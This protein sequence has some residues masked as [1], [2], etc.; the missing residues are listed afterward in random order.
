MTDGGLRMT[1][2]SVDGFYNMLLLGSQIPPTNDGSDNALFYA[3]KR[4]AL[5]AFDQAKLG[6][7]QGPFQ[8]HPVYTRPRDWYDGAI[9]ANWTT[10]TV[11]CDTGTS[12]TSDTPASSSIGNTPSTPPWMWRIARDDLRP[13]LQNSDL[14]ER[15]R[16]DEVV[17]D[18]PRPQFEELPGISFA[19]RTAPAK[20]SAVPIEN[21]QIMPGLEA[22]KIRVS[23]EESHISQIATR[24]LP[25]ISEI[26][27]TATINI[28]EIGTASILQPRLQVAR[29]AYLLRDT[30]SQPVASQQLTISLKYCLVELD[31][32]W[33]SLDYLST[34]GWF[35]PGYAAGWASTGT[36]ENNTG[37]FPVLPIACLVVKDLTIA[38]DA[39][40]D[41]D[42]AQQ[43]AAFGP[44]SLVGRTVDTITGTLRIEGMQIIGWVCQVMP[45]LP[46]LPSPGT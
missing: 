6:S 7:M 4:Q 2:K 38:V 36:A 18:T 28:G 31:R 17:L 44:F 8:F 23:V 40:D 10:Y 33:L 30:T 29:A 1:E 46:P 20:P 11:T 26:S 5:Q 41:V 13:I 32:H 12:S 24:P 42:A 35:M 14:L 39:T 3:L 19:G 43:S 25:I 34:Q 21:A 37:V 16:F 22:S 15:L 27:D 9:A 45:K